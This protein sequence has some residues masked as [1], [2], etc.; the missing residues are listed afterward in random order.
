MRQG[1]LFHVYT[2]DW[3]DGQGWM[4]LAAYAADYGCRLELHVVTKQSVLT[5]AMREQQRLLETCG[6]RMTWLPFPER[7]SE[8]AFAAI[9]GA[10]GGEGANERF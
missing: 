6:I 8:K 3:Q 10:E 7:M 2:A 9:T 5:Y 1:G 4:Q